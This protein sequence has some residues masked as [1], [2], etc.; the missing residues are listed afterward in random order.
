MQYFEEYILSFGLN[1]LVIG[2]LFES[3]NSTGAKNVCMPGYTKAKF[4][5]TL[6]FAV[7]NF[8]DARF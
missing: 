1:V 2:L 4:T 6:I 7:I 8:I 5:Q 3:T